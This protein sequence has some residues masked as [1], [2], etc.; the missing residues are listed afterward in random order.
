[1]KQMDTA[2]QQSL[3]QMQDIVLES[4][5]NGPTADIGSVEPALDQGSGSRATALGWQDVKGSWSGTLQA[6]GG[7][8][9]A[10]N[11]DFDVTGQD[12]QRRFESGTYKLDQVGTVVNNSFCV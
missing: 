6:Y 2:L 9:G 10:S 11:V 5:P 7:G 8:G 12:W 4:S 3:V 1:M